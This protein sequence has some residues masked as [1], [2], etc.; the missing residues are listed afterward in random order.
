MNIRLAGVHGERV[1]RFDMT[2]MIDVVLQLIIFF[3]FTSQLGQIARTEVEL[4]EEQ[5]QQD[6]LEERPTLVVDLDREGNLVLETKPITFPGL[7]RVVEREIDRAGEPA[8]LRV[9]IRPDRR[10][11]AS[12]LNRLAQRLAELGVRDWTIGTTPDGGRG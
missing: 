11:A 1:R 3:M 7:I 2:P 10:C 6:R 4:P 8:A 9:L 12:H 5:G